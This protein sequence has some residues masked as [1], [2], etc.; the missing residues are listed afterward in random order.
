MAG[1]PRLD[2]VDTQLLALAGGVPALP[3]AEAEARACLEALR[4]L[5]AGLF[6]PALAERG[7]GAA[8]DWHFDQHG[9]PVIVRDGT[10]AGSR[11]PSAVES[12][13]YFCCTAVT[14][15]IAAAP[16]TIELGGDAAGLTFRIRS[17]APVSAAVEE[18]LRD[19]VEAL[20][21]ELGISS[22]EDGCDVRASLPVSPGAEPDP[23]TRAT[24]TASEPVAAGT[25]EP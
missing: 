14:D 16:A 1:Q 9:E 10:G 3:G 23:A 8:L 11:F 2:A 13:A 5:A 21:G 24:A 25:E 18:L 12:A 6:P 22:G 20:G 19:R 7:L 15:D 4:E 17:A